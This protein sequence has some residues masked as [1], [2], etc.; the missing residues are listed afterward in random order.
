MNI[1]IL[2]A[3]MEINYSMY[4][5]AGAEISSVE[6][7]VDNYIYYNNAIEHVYIK[8]TKKLPHMERPD[9]VLDQIRTFIG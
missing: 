5:I 9:K 1:N 2:H 7:I 8:Y 4:I 6:T 3:I